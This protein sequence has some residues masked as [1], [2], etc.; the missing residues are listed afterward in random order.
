MSAVD[1]TFDHEN[2]LTVSFEFFPPKSEKMEER[3][4]ETVQRLEPID[5]AFVSVTYGAGGSTRERTHDTV[6]RIAQETNLRPAGHL[7]CVSAT[8]EEVLAVAE[9]YWQAGVK[10]IVALRGDP[11]EGMGARFEPHPGGFRNS[12]ELVA[13][14]RAHRPELGKCF[15]V[16][17]SCYPELHPES[18]GWDA[19][20]SYLKAKQDAGA[21]RAITQFFFEP[22]IY[23]AFLERARAGGV[24]IPIVPGIML[25]PNFKGL[26]KIVGLCGATL[27]AWLHD[28]Y[29]GL[30]EDAET[31]ELITANVAAELCQKLADQGVREFHF[32]T[33]NRAGLALSTCHLLGAKPKTA[34]AA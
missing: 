15:E 18:Q 2:G 10:H 9:D 20:I 4:W 8:K 13:G 21:D 3:L 17:V 23:F 19:E 30:D 27:P 22:E 29:E 31:R 11:P 33:L 34:R 28:L 5:P 16:S 1:Q 6:K 24:T 14:L 25:Q 12:V 7:T 26:T 32:Y